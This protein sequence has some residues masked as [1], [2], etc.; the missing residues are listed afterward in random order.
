MII[1]TRKYHIAKHYRGVDR[2]TRT[3]GG[4]ANTLCLHRMALTMGLTM[5]EPCIFLTVK[6]SETQ[7]AWNTDDA[8]WPLIPV[9]VMR[10]R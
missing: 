5:A 8:G 1:A 10:L 9:L 2:A 6:R 4:S 7:I 3:Q